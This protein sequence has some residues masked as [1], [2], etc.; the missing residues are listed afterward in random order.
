MN[1]TPTGDTITLAEATHGE[2]EQNLIDDYGSRAWHNDRYAVVTI[3][4]TEWYENATKG[5]IT[6]KEA[7]QRLAKRRQRELIKG[8]TQEAASLA[9]DTYLVID[10]ENGTIEDGYHRLVAYALA[11]I[12]TAKAVDLASEAD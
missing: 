11:G 12:K 1:V 10:S 9:Q 4:P 2:A 6:I 7:Y 8:Y 5:D 3:N